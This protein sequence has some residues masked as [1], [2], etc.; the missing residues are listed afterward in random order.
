MEPFGLYDC[1]VPCDAA[2]AVVV[3]ARD[4]AADLARPPVLVEAVGTQESMMQAIKATR[5]GGHV[6]YVG[7]PH[8]VSLDGPPLS[9]WRSHVEPGP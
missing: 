7:V 1:D 9:L 2:V 5:P 6:G 8:G 4:A 3:S